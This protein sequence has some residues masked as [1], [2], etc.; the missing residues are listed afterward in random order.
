MKINIRSTYH[1]SVSHFWG[2]M[3]ITKIYPVFFKI[4]ILLKFIVYLVAVLYAILNFLYKHNIESAIF[5]LS[6]ISIFTE[7]YFSNLNV[8][9]KKKLFISIQTLMLTTLNSLI[10]KF[11][12]VLFRGLSLLSFSFINPGYGVGKMKTY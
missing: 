3:A 4:L 5:Y 10:S 11:R 8:M 12:I 1:Y 9:R 7:I 2:F 6:T